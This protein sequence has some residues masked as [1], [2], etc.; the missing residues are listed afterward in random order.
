MKRVKT[1]IVKQR[2]K[3]L[4]ELIDT[5][6]PYEGMEGGEHTAWVNTEISPDGRHIVG[7]T[8]NYTKV[9]IPRYTAPTDL[10]GGELEEPLDTEL[11][12]AKVAVKIVSTARWHVVATL[13]RV[14]V[15]PDVLAAAKEPN[16]QVQIHTGNKRA[17]QGEEDCN[18]CGGDSN[19]C[20]SDKA[21]AEPANVVAC[22]DF[23]PPTNAAPDLAKPGATSA[24]VTTADNKLGWWW[25]LLGF[26]SAVFA[27]YCA[28][29]Q[30]IQPV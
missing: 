7:H 3:E 19:K 9:L 30:P 17:A 1:Q 13:L 2:S 5:F 8:K 12:G 24:V 25:L 20:T 6:R 4:T 28:A 29:V 26:L 18:T 23:H 14:L 11:Q 16:D 21:S 27:M 22:D 10:G 15:P